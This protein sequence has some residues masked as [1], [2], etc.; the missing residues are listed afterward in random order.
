M[1]DMAFDSELAVFRTDVL[2]THNF[3]TPLLSNHLRIFERSSS[4]AGA[5][6]L[7]QAL[8]AAPELTHVRLTRSLLVESSSWAAPERP[9]SWGCDVSTN[10]KVGQS[11]LKYLTADNYTH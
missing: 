8:P 10:W 2:L 6:S 5:A 1:P 11:S 7:N 3:Q 4:S 9:C